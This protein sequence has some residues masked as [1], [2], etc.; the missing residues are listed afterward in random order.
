MRLHALVFRTALGLALASCDGGVVTGADDVFRVD[1]RDALHAADAPRDTALADTPDT[2]DAIAHDGALED[3]GAGDTGDPCAAHPCPQWQRCIRMGTGTQCVDPCAGVSCTP[4]AMCYATDVNGMPF[5]RDAYGSPMGVCMDPCATV[6]C[7][8]NQACVP[9]AHGAPLG[10]CV[11]RC[12]CSNCGNCGAD[13]TFVGMQAYCGNPMGAPATMA[14][15]VPCTGGAGCIP[16]D[17]RGGICWP[18]EGCFS[19]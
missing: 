6:T 5:A 14:C 17:A 19:L 12:D 11:D 4:P 3:T 10:A 16:W 8:D 18:L 2:L 9:G 1:A 7:P 15:N 13:G